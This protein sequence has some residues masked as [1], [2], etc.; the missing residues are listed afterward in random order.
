MSRISLSVRS[1]SLWSSTRGPEVDLGVAARAAAGDA[2]QPASHAVRRQDNRRRRPAQKAC[3]KSDAVTFRGKFPAAALL[4]DVLGRLRGA[5]LLAVAV[6]LLPVAVLLL[7]MPVRTSLGRKQGL[8][9][10]LC[11]GCTPTPEFCEWGEGKNMQGNVVAATFGVASLLL[12]FPR[13]PPRCGATARTVMRRKAHWKNTYGNRFKT[14]EFRTVAALC[15]I[16]TF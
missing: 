6:L 15:S 4:S 8:G 9:H 16:T 1:L 14:A 13:V 12:H 5:V 10:N 7:P 11:G 2:A 3:K